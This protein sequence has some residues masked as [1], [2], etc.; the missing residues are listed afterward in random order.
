MHCCIVDRLNSKAEYMKTT[1]T[2]DMVL[3]G[4]SFGWK[5]KSALLKSD[6][7]CSWIQPKRKTMNRIWSISIAT[8]SAHIWIAHANASQIDELVLTLSKKKTRQT[9]NGHTSMLWENVNSRVQNFA[10]YSLKT[11]KFAENSKIRC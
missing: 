1:K 3:P 9:E 10:E 6:A 7:R 8:L 4:F 5:L 11:R 2:L